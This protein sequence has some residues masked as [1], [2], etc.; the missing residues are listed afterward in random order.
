MIPLSTTG[1][2]I[3][4]L[5]IWSIS[6]LCHKNR[7]YSAKIY[8]FLLLIMGSAGILIPELPL[9]GLYPNKYYLSNII[10][11][12]F[13][14]IITIIPWITYDKLYKYKPIFTIKDKYIGSLKLT[15]TVT[16]VLSFISI[17]YLLPYAIRSF[18]IG[19][20]EIRSMS[21]NESI[22]PQT[23]LTTFSVGISA[24]YPVTILF[25]YITLLDTRLSKY[26]VFL[27]IS[28]FTY[29][30]SNTAITGRDG[31]IFIPLI[32][33]V[34]FFVFKY[35]ISKDKLKKIKQYGIISGTL[36][37][38]VI[39]SVTINRFYNDSS[40]LSKKDSKHGLIYGTWGYFYQQPYVFDH[41]IEDFK[42]FYGFK[43]RLKFLDKIT[44]LKG[45]EYDKK[46]RKLYEMMF[47]TQ[48][49]EFYQISGYSSLFILTIIFTW[50][51]NYLANIFRRKRNYFA[52]F[53]SFAI[54]LN[55]TVAGM[56]YFRIGNSNGEFFLNIALIIATF[57]IP[58]ILQLR[59][60]VSNNVK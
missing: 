16:I 48:Y 44:D 9:M 29:L 36:L 53:I 20:E 26:T 60:N 11:F 22:L 49:A 14:L 38:L 56:F 59:E 3:V 27:I 55:F 34:M 4:L 30:V 18:L 12:A 54:Y 13:L 37:I 10:L 21:T 6:Y 41:V 17:A 2:S 42:S 28:S 58:N 33:I 19:A 50:F 51:F 31:F 25:V 35:S 23:F 47:G 32:Y 57:F 40:Y 43:R 52:M 7:L 46:R 15:F 24:L 8:Y 1:V 39:G 45:Q 5:I